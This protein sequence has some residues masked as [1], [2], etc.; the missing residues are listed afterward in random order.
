MSTNGNG[1]GQWLVNALLLLVI[2]LLGY[3]G[4]RIDGRVDKVETTA[5]GAEQKATRATDLNDA[6]YQE[7]V[8]WLTRIDKKLDD[9]PPR[10]GGR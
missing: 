3:W 7:I 1:R 10:R 5:T 2:G 6:R 8:R 9:D 4:T